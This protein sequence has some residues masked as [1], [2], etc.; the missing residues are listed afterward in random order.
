[1]SITVEIAKVFRFEAGHFLPNVGPAHQC[2][3]IHGHSYKLTLRV[4]GPI[5][6][7]L[8]WVMDLSDLSQQFEPWLKMLDHSF[9]NNI[10]GLENPTSENIA[11]WIMR[12]YG[13]EQ[14]LLSS[15]TLEATNR[16][17]V[18]VTRQDIDF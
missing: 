13:K 3:N 4:R 9:L 8:G 11:I 10:D 12:N 16:L 14:P 6:E 15:V 7:K 17:S 1:V 5:D 2:S 18:T